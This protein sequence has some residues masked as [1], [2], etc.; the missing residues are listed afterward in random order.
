MEQFWRR[1]PERED[2]LAFLSVPDNIYLVARREGVPAGEAIGFVLRRWDGKAPM[3]FLYSIDVAEP[4]RRQGI[5]RALVE[6]MKELGVEH[7][8]SEMFVPTN[9]ENQAAMALHEATGGARE[10]NDDVLFV[11]HSRDRAVGHRVRTHGRG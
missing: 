6:S 9:A 8:C 1:A 11:I 5:G 4:A 10:N 3:L 2:L 7:G